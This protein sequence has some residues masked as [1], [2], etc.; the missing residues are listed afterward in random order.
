MTNN[1]ALA[2]LAITMF[3]SLL[4]PA[5]D[6]SPPATVA[7]S[8]P[9]ITYLDA[10]SEEEAEMVDWAIQRY[11]EVGLQLPDLDISFPVTCGG[12]GGRYLVGQQQIELCRPHRKVVLHEF[13]HAWDDT[14]ATVDRNV[15]IELRGL[16]HWYEQPGE[17]SHGTGGEQLALIVTWG[18]MDV[19]LT[20][21]TS[22]FPG[23]P[24]DEQPRYLTGLA[25]GSPEMLTNLFSLLTGSSPL[26]PGRVV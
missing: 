14:S 15:F 25:D 8:P 16:E 12:K 6:T 17:R 21:R 26:S 3:A 1:A 11:L 2:T 18:L 23:Q 4:S 19:D 13:A 5:R 22:D 20:A 7:P 10:P 24:L 9:A